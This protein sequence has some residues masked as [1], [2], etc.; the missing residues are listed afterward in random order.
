MIGTHGTKTLNAR[1]KQESIR[2]NIIGNIPEY[3]VCSKNLT[4]RQKLWS[5]PTNSAFIAKFR[6]EIETFDAEAAGSHLPDIQD[7]YVK[8]LILPLKNWQNGEYILT[9]PV[10]SCGVL[11]EIFCRLKEQ[12][13]PFSTWYIQPNFRACSNHGDLMNKQGGAVKLLT[14][15]FMESKESNWTGSFVHLSADISDMNVSSGMVSVGFPAIT[16]IGGLVHTLERETGFNIDFAIG[17]SS[18]RHHLTYKKGGATARKLPSST[19][20]TQVY[21]DEVVGQGKLHLLLRG[22]CLNA[23]ATALAKVQRVAGG[24]LFHETIQIVKDGHAP[25]ATYLTDA[26][27]QK[28]ESNDSNSEKDALDNALALYGQNGSWK[29]CTET[30]AVYWDQKDY[31]YTLNHVGYA[32]L[33]TPRDKNNLRCD[34]KHA[35]SEPVFG[36]IRQSKAIEAMFWRRISRSWGVYWTSCK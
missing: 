32:L 5:L 6:D 12:K 26:C 35:W 28:F 21:S 27:N 3:Y 25:V 23:I 20:I 17:F 22:E 4:M 8:Q 13:L 18:L 33:E 10:P 1:V 29:H 24:V 16:A 11:Y 36:V 30:D 34:Y 14:R 31:R 9:S 7:G 19:P 15:S 2:S